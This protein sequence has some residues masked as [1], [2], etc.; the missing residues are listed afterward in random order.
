MVKVQLRKATAP[1]KLT[2]LLS[3]TPIVR[4][5]EGSLLC[6]TIIFASN[7]S[8]HGGV[9]RVSSWCRSHRH[10]P[11]PPSLLLRGPHRRFSPKAEAR[12]SQGLKKR[13]SSRQVAWPAHPSSV[14]RRRGATSAGW[15]ESAGGRNGAVE[16]EGRPRRDNVA[17]GRAAALPLPRSTSPSGRLWRSG[18]PS[19][20]SVPGEQHLRRRGTGLL[21]PPGSRLR[22]KS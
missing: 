9:L 11:R 16:H 3:S 15:G 7:T 12:F 5:R 21:L 17:F 8:R 1:K 18:V 13:E 22:T 10:V 20:P 2:L 4:I 6:D 14:G 19:W